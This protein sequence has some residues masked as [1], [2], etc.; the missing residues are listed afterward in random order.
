MVVAGFLRC[1]THRE[2]RTWRPARYSVQDRSY[3]YLS[4]LVLAYSCTYR[5]G[6]LEEILRDLDYNFSRCCRLRCRY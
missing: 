6:T 1:D 2:P 3:V 5:G 4:L